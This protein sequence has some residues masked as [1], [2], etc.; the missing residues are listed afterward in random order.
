MINKKVKNL[1]ASVTLA[2]TL[3]FNLLKARGVDVI[4]FCSGE[5]D[6][7]TPKHI[8]EAAKKSIDEGFTKYTSPSGMLELKKAVCDKLKREN[9]LDYSPDQII[10]SN[11]GKQAISNTMKALLD[12]GDE[13]IIPV[14][15]WVSYPEEV[16]LNGGTPVF[17]KTNNMRI[18]ADLIRKKITDKTKI[19][20]LNSPNNPT[21]VVCSK[22]ELRKIAELAIENNI[23]IISDEVYEHFTY[24]GKKHYSIASL[25]DEVKNITITINSVSKTYA[26]TGWRIGYSAG[27]ENVIKAMASIQ[28]HETSNPCSIAQ[29]AAFEALKGP[30]D[31]VRKMKREF[32]KRR[33]IIVK[34]LN[35]IEG[36]KCHLPEGAFYAFPN[37]RGTGMKSLEFCKLLLKEAKVAAIPGISFGA[38][39]NIR[40]SYAS[41]LEDIKK[42]V[43]RIRNFVTEKITD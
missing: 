1:T 3:E 17:C 26:M 16:K 39:N 4:G 34:E 22:N 12:K 18:T 5:P 28:S 24:D 14:P 6:F 7:D 40:L 31:D 36:I 13:V 38:D 2:I 21:G 27:P 23:I 30:Q 35:K 25:S 11:G 29:K 37:I 15:Y 43:E 42:G 19:L 32:N 9:N 41:P 8:K 33:K 10:I 20:I